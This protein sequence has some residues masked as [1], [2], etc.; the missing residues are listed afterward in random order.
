MSYKCIHSYGYVK[1]IPGWNILNIG[2]IFVLN[3]FQNNSFCRIGFCVVWSDYVKLHYK[4][5][6]WKFVN[7]DIHYL[8]CKVVFMGKPG[9]KKH[10]EKLFLPRARRLFL[11][12]HTLIVRLT[13]FSYFYWKLG[14]VQLGLWLT[15]H[16][17]KNFYNMY[18]I[19]VFKI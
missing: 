3:G 18:F 19:F 12:L 9:K 15:S 1:S 6:L 10:Q 17:P 4:S 5:C 13:I 16:K 14:N 2:L 11:P 8:S 7:I